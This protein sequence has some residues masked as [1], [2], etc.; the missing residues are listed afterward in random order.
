MID[1]TKRRLLLSGLAFAATHVAVARAAEPAKA[2]EGAE[3]IDM[4]EAQAPPGAASASPAATTP[5]D[6]K[7]GAGYIPG[8]RRQPSLGLS[9]YSPQGFIAVPGIDPP[10]GAPM[11]SS[12]MRFDFH[13][14]MQV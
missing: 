4:P 12:A 10:F 11:G 13:G 2:P 5:P 9:P 14:Y 6:E 7:G 1:M 8:Y 3:F